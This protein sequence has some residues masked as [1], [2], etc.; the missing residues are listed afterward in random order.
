M[1]LHYPKGM[2]NYSDFT[3]IY[4]FG[5]PR[6]L[7]QDNQDKTIVMPHVVTCRQVLHVCSWMASGTQTHAMESQSCQNSWNPGRGRDSTRWVCILK[8]LHFTCAVCPYIHQHPAS[9]FFGADWSAAAL[10]NWSCE[11]SDHKEFTQ[12]HDMR[13]CNSYKQSYKS[14]KRL[15]FPSRGVEEWLSCWSLFWRF[16]LPKATIKL[17]SEFLFQNIFSF[18][19]YFKF[20]VI[21]F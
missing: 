1:W 10:D 20:N 16:F 15:V 3:V 6:S 11:T 17:S 18:Q 8:K 5:F 7:N 21:L 14:K 4:D 9:M 12:L 19:L 13:L 2:G